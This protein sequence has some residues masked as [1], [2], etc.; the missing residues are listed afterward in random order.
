MELLKVDLVEMGGGEVM[1]LMAYLVMWAEL[2]AMGVLPVEFLGMVEMA[3]MVGLVVQEVGKF[4]ITYKIN[5]GKE[6]F[7]KYTSS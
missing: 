3:A 7:T 4:N 6:L 5:F 2:E 1:E